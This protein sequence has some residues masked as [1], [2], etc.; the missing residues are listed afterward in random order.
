MYMEGGHNVEQNF[1]EAYELYNEAAE[2]ATALG[3]GRLASKYYQL[4]EEAL[5]KAD[6]WAFLIHLIANY[7]YYY[8]VAYKYT[9]L[10]IYYIIYMRIIFWNLN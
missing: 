4:A 5:S 1:Q 6:S 3:K 7:Y 2:K 10:Y 8:F 9:Y